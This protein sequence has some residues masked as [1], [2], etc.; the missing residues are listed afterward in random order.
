M[1]GLNTSTDSM[2]WSLEGV[3]KFFNSLWLSDTIWQQR[4]RVDSKF[5]PS[6][7][8]TALLC[9]DV[10]H[11]MGANLE[12]ALE[13]W[14]NIGSGNV[15]LPEGT[16]PLPEPM[17]TDHQWSSSDIHLR[18]ISQEIPQPSITKICLKITYLNFHSNSPGVNE[19]NG[20]LLS[21]QYHNLRLS[22]QLW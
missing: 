6:Q 17:L 7:W 16:K 3:G 20:H 9:N 11:W 5:A 21:C 13:I 12:S 15:L 22:L 10:S 2:G 8:E 1:L 4:S 19:L 18:S 14:V